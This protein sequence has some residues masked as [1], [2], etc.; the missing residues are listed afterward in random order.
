MEW[1]VQQTD[2]MGVKGELYSFAFIVALSG[3]KMKD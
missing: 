1:R 3:V 2:L